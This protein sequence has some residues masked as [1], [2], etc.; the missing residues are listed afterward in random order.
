MQFSGS[1]KTETETNETIV[2]IHKEYG[3]EISE[4]EETWNK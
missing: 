2:K 4:T 1:T 3:A